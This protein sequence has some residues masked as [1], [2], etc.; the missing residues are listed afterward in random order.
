MIKSREGG[1]IMKNNNHAV[2]REL[3]IIY[4]M[5]HNTYIVLLCFS[6]G[7]FSLADLFFGPRFEFIPIDA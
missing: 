3:K 1:I 4:P 5:V 7:S 2:W 6:V